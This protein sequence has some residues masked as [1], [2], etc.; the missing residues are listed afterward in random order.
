V[1][2]TRRTRWWGSGRESGAR[3]G[4]TMEGAPRAGRLYSGEQSRLRGGVIRCA[5]ASAS[6]GEGCGTPGAKTQT[7]GGAKSAGRR[8]GAADRCTATPASTNS[9]QRERNQG[10]KSAGMVPYLVTVLR[11]AWSGAWSSRWSARWAWITDELGQRRRLSAGEAG[12][13]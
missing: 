7:R 9:L 6:S 2:G 5:E 1:R 13:G 3:S 11:E 12:S 8:V 10:K 4:R